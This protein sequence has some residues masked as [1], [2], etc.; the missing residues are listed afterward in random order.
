[1][2]ILP[3][4]T[5]GVSLSDIVAP[6]HTLRR[7]AEQTLGTRQSLG[8]I[9]A[10]FAEKSPLEESGG[11]DKGTGERLIITHAV[12]DPGG[13]LV[14]VVIIARNLA[15][16]GQVQSTLRYSRKLVALGRLSVGVAHEVK[17]PLNAMMIH[18]ELL[19]QQFTGKPALTRGKAG[20]T[21]RSVAVASEP[22]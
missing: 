2:A 22:Q 19:R 8:P 7:L 4:A 21:G 5:P 6:E 18:L 10:T 9:S 14:G 1:R 20:G 11:D 12:S 13:Q 3:N 15:Y 17:N 16:L